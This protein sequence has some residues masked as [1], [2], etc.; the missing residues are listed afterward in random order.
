MIALVGAF[1]AATVCLLLVAVVAASAEAKS[2]TGAQPR[3]G[4]QDPSG[5][6]T[7]PLVYKFQDARFTS[8]PK[9]NAV[10]LTPKCDEG[11]VAIGGGFDTR[12]TGTSSRSYL[13]RP[14]TNRPS[15]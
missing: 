2:S 15:I 7:N 12:Y 9:T 5:T 10:K 6:R 1:V 13:L 11:Y 8:S 4:V 14:T 3:P